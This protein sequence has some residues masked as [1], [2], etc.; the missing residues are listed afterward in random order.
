MFAHW[1]FKIFRQGKGMEIVTL[2]IPDP[3]D[4]AKWEEGKIYYRDSK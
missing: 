1:K 2:V 4:M 3:T